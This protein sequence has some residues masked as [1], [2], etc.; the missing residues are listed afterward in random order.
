Y[1]TTPSAGMR[2]DYM[3][4]TNPM[5]GFTYRGVLSPQPPNNNNN[6]HQATF[7][8]NGQW[9]EMYHNRIVASRNGDGTTYHRNLAIDAFSHRADGTIVQMVNTVN[10]V[11]QLKYLDPFK[12]VEAETMSEHNGI[13][14]EVC[15]A[16]GMNVAFIDNNDWIMVEG[17]DLGSGVAGFSA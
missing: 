3:T 10:G 6:N 7:Q 13:K 11:K 2:I 1:S 4:S 14:T 12:R 17:V 5:S 16:G 8:M 9:Y 15:S